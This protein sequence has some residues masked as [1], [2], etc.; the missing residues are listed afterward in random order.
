M[1]N[2]PILYATL[3]ALAGLPLGYGAA[4]LMAWLAP[5]VALP[6][7]VRGAMPFARRAA[8]FTQVMQRPLT[9]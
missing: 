1:S 4:Q 5:I 8:R 6:F 3:G 9:P 2:L 7:A